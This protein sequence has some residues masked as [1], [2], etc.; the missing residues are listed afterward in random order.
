MPLA[1]REDFIDLV[2]AAFFILNTVPVM[3]KQ[4]TMFSY[5]LED[6]NEMHW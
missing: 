1:P 2:P 6:C 3:E 5:G 4:Q